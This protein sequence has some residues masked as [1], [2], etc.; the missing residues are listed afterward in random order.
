MKD[1]EE[2]K[3]FVIGPGKYKYTA[4]MKDGSKVNFGHKDYQQYRD[5]VP[6]SMGGGKWSSQDHNDENRRRSY[7][8]RHEGVL[9]KSGEYA[10]KIKYSPS[11]FSYHYLW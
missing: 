11:W 1:L 4:I 5:S 8:S 7:R 9:T 2:V 10:Y 3:K 6:V